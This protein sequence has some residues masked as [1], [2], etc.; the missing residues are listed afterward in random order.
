LDTL[1]QPHIVE[2]KSV[3]QPAP[4]NTAVDI[5]YNTIFTVK[6]ALGVDDV[7]KVKLLGSTGISFP[8]TTWP[9]H[10]RQF[11]SAMAL[12]YSIESDSPCTL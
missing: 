8:H 3:A 1:Y 5:G 6:W 10:G 9:L 2:V 12:C 11:R 7:D 4:V